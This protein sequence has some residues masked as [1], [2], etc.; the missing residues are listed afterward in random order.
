VRYL[1]VTICLYA[2]SL[3]A[4]AQEITGTWE[5]YTGTRFTCYTKLCIVNI[6]GTYT[7]YTYD[8][9]K[10]SG[11]CKADFALVYNKKKKKLSGEGM[12]LIENTPGHVLASYKLFYR[13]KNGEEYL[14][15]FVYMK[16]DSTTGSA[17]PVNDTTGEDPL[18]PEFIQLK[19]ISDKADSTDYMRLMALS[20]CHIDSAVVTITPIVSSP[21]I[22]Q[23]IMEEP[24]HDIP[25]A[26]SPEEAILQMQTSRFN[27]TLSVIT[28]TTKELV[29]RVVDNAI[30]DGDTISIIH[31][32]KLIAGRI[33]VSAKPFPIKILL[34]KG[35][36]Y[37][38][39]ILVAHN[40]GSIPPN[41]SLVLIDAGDKQYQLHAFTDLSKNALIIFRYTG[42]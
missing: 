4:Q 11:H 9:D 5:E 14:E 34:S 16:P 40:L 2:L 42:E 18:K 30:T 36:P 12:A 10:D 41:T 15:G 27:D 19:K 17:T 8:R 39:L 20:P 21:P 22:E 13:L 26:I 32:G 1:F 3:T 35:N 23:K 25:V 6:C 37:H 33:Q 38:E 7:G 31:N 28:T 29:I 24:V